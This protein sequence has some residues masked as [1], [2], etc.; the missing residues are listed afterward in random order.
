MQNLSYILSLLL[1]V[2]I[3]SLAVSISNNEKAEIENT[4][5]STN[6]EE[7]GNTIST[8]R[9]T[10]KEMDLQIAKKNKDLQKVDSVLKS[11]N[12]RIGQ[13][14]ELV[15][16]RIVI[17][18]HDTTYIHDTTVVEIKPGIFR[19]TFREQKNCI[20]FE[21]FVDC[22]DNK[23]NIAITKRESDIEVYDIYLKRKWYQIFKPKYERLVESNCGE[24]EI[25]R[26][27]KER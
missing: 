22:T 15:K 24:V 1:A 6:L 9:L 19:T 23:P 17:V 14:E 10:K 25:L 21:G 11:K 16:T 13:L 20:L 7:Y 3:I 26:V 12:K 4:R 27:Y 8:L 2:V 5:L 18:D